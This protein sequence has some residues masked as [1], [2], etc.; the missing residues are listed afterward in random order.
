VT[1]QIKYI[2][3]GKGL[4]MFPKLNVFVKFGR[5]VSTAEAVCLWVVKWHLQ[6][7]VPVPDVYG[8]RV[9]GQDVF[10]FMELVPGVILRERWDQLS[11]QDRL[12]VCDELRFM[13][14]QLTEIAPHRAFYGQVHFE[15]D[16][17]YP[18]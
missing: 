10:L 7:Q 12:L 16:G 2:V 3:Y 13:I 9:D 18:C 6:G 15:D 14:S 1:K 11:Y 4:A 17:S 5:K 8:W